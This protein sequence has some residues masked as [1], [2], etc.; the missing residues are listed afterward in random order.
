MLFFTF[1]AP[2]IV[3]LTPYLSD[4]KIF[5]CGVPFTTPFCMYY[6]HHHIAN[7]EGRIAQFLKRLRELE[8]ATPLTFSRWSAA[9]TSGRAFVMTPESISCLPGRMVDVM[10]DYVDGLPE[11][12][13]KF[14]E[15]RRCNTEDFME[16]RDIHNNV[17]FPMLQ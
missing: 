1:Q 5:P 3:R 15:N 10:L 12:K 2:R 8:M 6:Y 11:L 4:I 9:K 7:A 16:P 14:T 13:V 17:S